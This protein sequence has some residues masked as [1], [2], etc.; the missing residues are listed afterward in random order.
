MEEEEDD[1]NVVLIRPGRLSGVGH[2]VEEPNLLGIRRAT[3][4]GSLGGQRPLN[5]F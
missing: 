4:I 3:G 5:G 2:N 1:A